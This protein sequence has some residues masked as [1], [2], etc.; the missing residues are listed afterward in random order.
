MWLAI[1]LAIA[2][3]GAFAYQHFTSVYHLATVQP[4]VLYRDGARS[5]GELKRAVA[6][7]QPKT[8]I[9]LVTEEEIADPATPHFREEFAWLSEQGIRVE[10][11]P[12][13]RDRL[14]SRDDVQRFLSWTAKPENQPV[15]IHC[16]QGVRR[17]GMMVA[18]F[19]MS[20]LGYDKE[21]A[22]QAILT[23]GH[24]EST[25]GEIRSFIDGYDSKASTM[26]A[27]SK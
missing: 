23:F 10:R 18:A 9:C 6:R 13:R 11:I 24:S 1:F 2:V 25:I 17:T 4:G 8:V 27:T 7:V 16:A 15:L 26:P 3:G 14:P 12:I 5:L 22:K 20:V 19:Q 21:R